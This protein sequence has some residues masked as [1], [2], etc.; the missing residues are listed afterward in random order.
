MEK[1]CGLYVISCFIIRNIV[2]LE[3]G[4]T[5][6]QKI[7]RIRKLVRALVFHYHAYE[8]H[9]VPLGACYK[10]LSCFGSKTCLASDYPVIGILL[11]RYHL[12]VILERSFLIGF[13]RGRDHIF[14]CSRY[15][16][17]RFI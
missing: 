14:G 3:T 15:H 9:A 10:R 6:V 12:V 2:F 4:K 16:A 5:I 13:V 8:L 17:Q 11:T 1:A 7:R